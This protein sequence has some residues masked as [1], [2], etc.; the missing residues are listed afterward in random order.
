MR[1]RS[2]T[3]TGWISYTLSRAEQ[4]FRAPTGGNIGINGGRYY[5]APYDKTHDLSVVSTRP[6][7]KK[8]TLGSTLADSLLPIRSLAI[9]STDSWSPST[10]TGT[11]PAFRSI[12]AST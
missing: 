8:W 6:L 10:A 11:R 2:G 4:Q 9:R 3:L 1:C 7:G 5:P 12:T